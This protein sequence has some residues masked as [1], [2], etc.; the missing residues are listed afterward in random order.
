[1]NPADGAMIAHD[2]SLWTLFWQA[3]IVVKLVMIGLLAASVWCWAIIIDKTLLF[4]RTKAQMDQFE[5]VFWSG[6]SLEELYRSLNE[7][8][9]H[10]LAHPWLVEQGGERVTAGG[11]GRGGGEG[12]HAAT[13][14]AGRPGTTRRGNPPGRGT[15]FRVTL[16]PCPR[17][18]A[19][20]RPSPRACTWRPGRRPSPS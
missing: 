11:L 6:Q 17:R 1:M 8:P 19:C 9:V 15:V 18:R 5:D 20:P 16:T 14:R 2:M 4:S 10:G 13:L 12:R 3:H 7:R